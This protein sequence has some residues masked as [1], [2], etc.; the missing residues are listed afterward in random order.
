MRDKV[1]VYNGSDAQEARPGDRP[2]DFAADVKLD[3]AD[4][5][6]NFFMVKQGLSLPFE[7]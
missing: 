2:E 1:R 5:P 7:P 3:D 6:H 4:Q